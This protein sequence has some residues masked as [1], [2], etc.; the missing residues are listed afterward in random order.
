MSSFPPPNPYFNGIIY[1]SSFF[2][3]PALTLSQA[4]AKYLK[5]TTP[6]I[7]SALETFS[8]GINTAL[9][10]STSSA[11]NMT[12]GNNLAPTTLLT[13]GSTGTYTVNNGTLQTQSL[14]S[15][16]TGI[17]MNIGANH[18]SSISI[19]Q[20]GVS[21]TNLY[22]TTQASAI[23]AFSAS[24]A[25]TIGNNLTG[26]SLTL[27]G[28]G[29]TTIS[30]PTMSNPIT[31]SYN[32]NTITAGQIG[33]SITPTYITPYT[34]SPSVVKNIA[35]Y[36]LPIGVYFIQ[37]SIQTPTPTTYQGLGISLASATIEYECWSNIL[38]D[39]YIWFALCVSRIVVI[40]TA[41]T[42]Y[43]IIAQAGDTRTL[44]Q[45]RTQCFRI[46]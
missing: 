26:G 30:K 5:K 27:G 7:A 17:N 34:L 40:T 1:D 38:T 25:M 15:V 44:L 24:S 21:T 46:A 23:N 31:P 22:G 3:I 13:L 45:V 14:A 33:Y 35:S 43:Y 28:T 29:T 8:G 41:S 19:G 4:N 2:K 6:D 32:P 12:I 18:G 16:N 36:S 10:N 9:I 20:A 37:A 42:P 39:S 11:T